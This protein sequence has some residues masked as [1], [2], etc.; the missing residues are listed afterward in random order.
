MSANRFDLQY[1]PGFVELQRNDE[2]EMYPEMQPKDAVHVELEHGRKRADC[3]A[4]SS[5]SPNR[6]LARSRF[7]WTAMK[8]PHIGPHRNSSRRPLPDDARHKRR[9]WPCAARAGRRQQATTEAALM[10]AIP[11]E[12]GLAACSLVI[13]FRCRSSSRSPLERRCAAPHRSPP[14]PPVPSCPAT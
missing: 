11:Q 7:R 6:S 8:P 12:R 5:R 1:G 14:S 13:A 10:F 3:A 9:P 4:T 2:P